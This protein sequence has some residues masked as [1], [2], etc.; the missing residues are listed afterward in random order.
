ML[1]NAD[2]KKQIAELLN[3]RLDVPWVPEQIELTLFEHAV[4]LIDTTVEGLLPEAFSSLLRDGSLGI[5]PSQAQVF[6]ERLLQ[7]LN[8][9]VDLPYLDEV[10]EASLFK[11]MIDPLVQAMVDGE[12]ID[13]VLT[14]LKGQVGGAEANST[15]STP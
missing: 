6:G 13:K 14:R 3:A 5:D 8:K 12:S 9:R 15:S 7:A 1:L 4:G 10:Q 11:M 2:E